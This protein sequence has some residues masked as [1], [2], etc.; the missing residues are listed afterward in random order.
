MALEHVP[1]EAI[2]VPHFFDVAILKVRSEAVED[3]FSFR[4]ECVHPE[5]IA[6]VAVKINCI[7]QI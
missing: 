5:A 1:I 3:G 7:V 6:A 2:I 4:A